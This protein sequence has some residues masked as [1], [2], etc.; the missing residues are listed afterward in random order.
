MVA[1]AQGD[2]AELADAAVVLERFLDLPELSDALRAEAS[3]KWGMTLLTREAVDE[4]R[5]VFTE[6]VSRFLVESERAA[7]MNGVG[8]YWLSRSVFALG[9]ILE[10]DGEADEARRLYRLMIA[11]NMPGRTISAKRLGSLSAVE[12]R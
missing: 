12:V 3:H 10:R 6:I 2:R 8:Q 1:L 5:Q 11:L 4:A 9:E 7:E